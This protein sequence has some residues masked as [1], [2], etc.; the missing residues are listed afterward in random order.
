MK[1]IILCEHPVIKL[2]QGHGGPLLLSD[3]LDKEVTAKG[4][5]MINV[6]CTLT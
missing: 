4:L 2:E 1:V 5:E 3:R 6:M